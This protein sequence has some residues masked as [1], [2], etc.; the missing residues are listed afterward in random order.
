MAVAGLIAVAAPALAGCAGTAAPAIQIATAY[1]P[2]P[3]SPGTTV[4]YVIIRNNGPADRLVA[5]STSAGGRVSFEAARAPGG[6]AMR[7]EPAVRVP[8][9]ATLQMAPD[10]VHLVITGAGPLH[11]GKEIRL[12]LTFAHAGRVSVVAPVTNPAS[13]SSSWLY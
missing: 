5:A 3:Q 1:V 9:H 4:A 11:G 13:S 6:A 7:T 10:G 8:A 12:T 2:V